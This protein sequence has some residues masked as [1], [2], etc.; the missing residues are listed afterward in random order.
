VIV[1]SKHLVG[2]RSLEAA[3][4]LRVVGRAGAGVDNVDVEAATARGVLVVNV[5][6]GN[7]VSAAEHTMALLL[8]LVRNVPAACASLRAGR[9]ERAAFLGTELDGKILGV[10]GLGRIGRAV[11]RR[12]TA[13]GMSVIATDPAVGERE[14]DSLG[15][16]WVRLD[17][18]LARAD[19]VSLHVPLTSETRHMI[20]ATTLAAMRPGAR[21]VNCARGGLV[22]EV[23]VAQALASGRL[24]GAAFDVY[25][26][27]AGP[28]PA[29][30]D[31]PGFVGTPHIG[32]ATTE[33]RERVGIAVARDVAAYLVEGI[34]RNS[35]NAPA[36]GG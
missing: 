27:E 10:V 13:F 34:V 12:A 11:A 17:A 24:A 9:W 1:H 6:A 28:A 31:H 23:A 35:V 7:T 14:A 29:L 30:S 20:D 2:G 3:P 5:P 36:G 33:A 8:A 19:V 32:G 25:E 21:L 26:A 15:V 16:E 4:R 22:D 18:L